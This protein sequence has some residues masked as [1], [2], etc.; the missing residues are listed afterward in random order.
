ML[1]PFWTFFGA[2]LI[3]KAVVKVSLQSVFVITVFSKEHLETLIYL[4]E[5]YIPVFSGRAQATFE[6]VRKQYHRQPGQEIETGGV[7]S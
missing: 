7:R 6:G 4:I 5:T 3:G 1:V 2:T